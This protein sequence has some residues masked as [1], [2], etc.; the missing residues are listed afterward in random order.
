MPKNTTVLNTENFLNDKKIYFTSDSSSM[1]IKKSN[2]VEELSLWEKILFDIDI[3]SRINIFDKN[4]KN[5]DG[6]QEK[7]IYEFKFK[8]CTFKQQNCK[9][10]IFREITDISK[11]EYSRSLEKVSEIMIASTSHDMRT[12]L[13]TIINMIKLVAQKINDQ[14]IQKWLNVAISS[15]NLLLY[16]VNDTLDYFQIKSGKFSKTEGPLNIDDLVKGTFDLVSVQMEKKNIEKV[17]EID[18]ALYNYELISDQQRIRQVLINLLTNALK[19]T[20]S[21]FISIKVFVVQEENRS[22]QNIDFE[23]KQ[24]EA[25]DSSIMEKKG[26][27]N[28]RFEVQ[29]SGIGIK[30][31]DF[32]RL[33]K[34]FGKLE[35]TENLNTCG[36]GLGLTICNKILNQL[37][38]ELKVKSVFNQGT[39][40]YFTLNLSFIAVDFKRELSNNL[41]VSEHSQYSEL[42]GKNGTYEDLYFNEE[43]SDYS[44]LNHQN[45]FYFP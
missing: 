45:I 42:A 3:E 9:L 11:I 20:F 22:N 17:L 18:S 15:T 36:I 30:E 41:D 23:S 24:E 21:G 35:Q 1:Q 14:Q 19:F 34:V 25:V 37:G 28:V 16:L 7:M 2:N 5:G 44:P 12:P 31:E 43:N 4:Q 13:N 6:I 27:L 33:F 8:N 39:C 26:C 32:D 10:M 29:D 38:S 40:F